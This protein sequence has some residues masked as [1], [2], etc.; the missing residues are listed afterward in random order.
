LAWRTPRGGYHPPP[1]S[2]PDVTAG[3]YTRKSARAA[4]FHAVLLRV[5]AQVATLLGYVVLVRVLPE[6]EF[7]IY[8]LFYAT[9]PVVGTLLSFGME[10]TLRRYQPEYLR[11]G[12]NRLAHWLTRRIGQLR[13]I[14]T[15]LFLAIAFAFWDQVA[16]L[17]KIA[18]YREHFMLFGLLMLSHFQCQL[19]TMALSAHLLQKYS[20]GLTAIFSILKLLGYG[21]AV[22]L[23]NLDLWTAIVA[24]IGAYC[25]FFVGL[26]YAYLVK[27]DR[28]HGTTSRFTP[29]EAKRLIRYATF[30]S[31][32]DAGTL[33]LD[34]R[35]DN[36][37][38]AAFLA[39]A[40]VGAYSFA[41]RFN[42]MVG[43]VS[44]TTLLDSVIQPLF[45]SLD[46]RHDKQRVHRYFSL[47]MTLT[48]LARLP[49]FVFTAIYH[50][51]IVEVVF[52]GHF[53]DYSYLLALVALF[54]LGS[55]ISTP[56]TLV[57]Q[58]EEKAQFILA[59]KIFG[60]LG[61]AAS[62]IL[63]PLIGV[64]GAVIA[65]G[66]AMLLKNLFIWWF[67]RD[68]ARWTNARGFVAAAT[69]IWVTFAVVAFQERIWLADRPALALVAGLA[70]WAL[71]L[72]VQLRVAM[73][74]EHRAIVAGL[75]S[76]PERRI[77]QWLRIA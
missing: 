35:K 75:F 3:P 52:D 21:I 43:R 15:A 8:S 68:L 33:T 27:A 73:P 37:F 4:A 71:F 48:L 62:L 38:L 55:V 7:G 12:E 34:T 77:L 25:V 14:T 58:L 29:Q 65:S 63:I 47:L 59:S 53:L 67:V 31:F 26:K 22:A 57:A 61:I 10:D 39:P 51:E 50:R 18:D 6:T 69:A 32:N 56:I 46:Y 5:P 40:A 1:L 23:W 54:S 70:I 20:V 13:L 64:V 28:R 9:L 60:I 19:L 2:A 41:N 16:P 24:D 11:K 36:F 76:G 30:Y 44:P 66:A 72:L 49:I 45:V 74:P 17:F 42:E